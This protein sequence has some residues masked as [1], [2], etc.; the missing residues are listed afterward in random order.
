MKHK[1]LTKAE[2]QIMQILWKIGKGFVNDV[3]AEFP[4]SKPAYTTVSTIIRILEKKGFLSHKALGNSHQYYPVV[5]KDEYAKFML[6]DVVSNYFSNSFSGMVSFFSLNN[7]INVK[8]MEEIMKLMKQEIKQK[9][10]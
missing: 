10:G 6:K 2:E 8:E 7:K 9:K 1:E 4:D 3:V 5:S